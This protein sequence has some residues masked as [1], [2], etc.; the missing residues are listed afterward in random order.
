MHVI[1]GGEQSGRL[2]DRLVVCVCVYKRI[3][4]YVVVKERKK[5]RK[6]VTSYVT[7]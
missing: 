5:K 3:G 4:S 1:N 6:S 7:S 2:G